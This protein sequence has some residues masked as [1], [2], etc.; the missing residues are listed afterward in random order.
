MKSDFIKVGH[1]LSECPEV[2]SIATSL[3][4]SEDEVVGKLIRIWGWAK[5]QDIGRDSFDVG[6]TPAWID[7]YL[8]CPGFAKAMSYERW[9]FFNCDERGVRF[10]G[11]EDSVAVTDH[12]EYYGAGDY[13]R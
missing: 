9:I 5:R 13:D 2:I 12:G 1:R 4:L 8:A 3:G 10:L 11:H 7:R 6:I